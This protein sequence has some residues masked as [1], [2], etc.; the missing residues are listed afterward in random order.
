MRKKYR[1]VLTWLILLALFVVS[2][3]SPI[4]SLAEN[5]QD[6][7]H[8][9]TALSPED[10]AE[11][12]SLSESIEKNNEVEEDVAVSQEPAEPVLP[13]SEDGAESITAVEQ[14]N[15]EAEKDSPVQRF[16]SAAP[17][18]LKSTSPSPP[19]VGSKR[20][21]QIFPDAELAL[22]V[23][24]TL[25]GAS[26]KP[27]RKV[28]QKD[29]DKLEIL[30]TDKTDVNGV[31]YGPVDVRNIEGIQ[32]LRN[33]QEISFQHAKYVTDLSPFSVANFL[34]L[35]QL[36][37]K[38]NQI[39]DLT[40][41][42]QAKMP[43]LE[44][45]YLDYNNVTSLDG[46][47]NLTTLKKFSIEDG[48]N[49]SGN[50]V[51]SLDP[52]AG[53]TS[54]EEF[55]GANNKIAS[56]EPL[57]KLSKLREVYVENNALENIEG[58]SGKPDL[59]HFSVMNQKIKDISPLKDSKN[60]Q[61]VYFYNNHISSVEPLRGMK[62]LV[63]VQLDTNEIYDLSPLSGAT[64][65]TTGLT[66]TEQTV[67]L[68]AKS[69]TYLLP[70]TMSNVVKEHKGALVP[71]KTISNSGKYANPNVTWNLE[72]GISE[73]T[74]TWES[75]TKMTNG[76]SRFTGIITQPL[77]ELETIDMNISNKIIGKQPTGGVIHYEL[78]LTTADGQVIQPV[79]N[80]LPSSGTTG[81][82]T[83]SLA[84]DG[85]I[86]VKALPGTTYE[87]LEK[88]DTDLYEAYYSRNHPSLVE[89][90]K[91]PDDRKVTGTLTLTNDPNLLEFTNVA[92]VAFQ[93]KNE[94]EPDLTGGNVF[95]DVVFTYPD[96]TTSGETFKNQ[97]IIA[98]QVWKK[99]VPSGTKYEIT[100][101]AVPKYEPSATITENSVTLPVHI[102]K[103]SESLIVTGEAINDEDQVLFRNTKVERLKIT[104]KD[105]SKYP[106]VNQVFSYQ[107]SL[108]KGKELGATPA[109]YTAKKYANGQL[110]E[111]IDFSTHGA[112]SF[113]LN[114]N[115]ELVF[116]ELPLDITYTIT[117][118]GVPT[119]VTSQTTTAAGNDS[120]SAGEKDQGLTVTTPM[121]LGGNQVDF[122]NNSDYQ[123]VVTGVS[124]KHHGAL[125]TVILLICAIA[126][127]FIRLIWQIKH[128]N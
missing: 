31:I 1:L 12:P 24:R 70:F 96:G 13:E 49:T 5:L 46:I 128:A 62:Q 94:F 101:S 50:Q 103:I 72:S 47:Q 33:V 109:G 19:L 2:F 57:E 30:S 110:L 38:N 97:S 87:V 27:S 108:A 86:P 15:Q 89:M 17:Q 58:M 43:A 80:D 10:A 121:S 117:Q 74:Y 45:L 56:L 82:G 34:N 51:T 21:D 52:M 32:Y 126:A 90:A 119:Y 93:I 78:K 11:N 122:I 37:F 25:F 7:P 41:L 123:P 22:V 95:Y 9:V 118:S 112:T 68:P 116:D 67:K 85:N 106:N 61:V 81:V 83:F 99:M 53:F 44:E 111:T 6:S 48:S 104:N 16:Q 69:Y 76:E 20:I 55:Y 3:I 4:Q 42:G 100:Q 107:L 54:L 84:N 77:V 60:L 114:H 120:N 102:G 26:A 35:K 124:S 127:Y 18:A 98:G 125:V 88:V 29:L 28:E 39:S 75:A 36:Y 40:P 113:T 115:E 65:L 23:A 91:L 79:K 14:E 64:G 66:A 8:E 59:T 105:T 71:P 92:K 63:T 73:V